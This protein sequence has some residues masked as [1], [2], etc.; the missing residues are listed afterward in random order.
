[1]VSQQMQAASMFWSFAFGFPGGRRATAL[2]VV[3]DNECLHGT[4][5]ATSAGDL[6][7]ARKI[8]ERF[9]EL[10]HPTASPAQRQALTIEKLV[11]WRDDAIALVRQQEGSIRKVAAALLSHGSLNGA[12]LKALLN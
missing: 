1:M 10:A 9:V 8:A 6:D 12:E 7:R 5:S 3:A 11:E 4:T 2:T